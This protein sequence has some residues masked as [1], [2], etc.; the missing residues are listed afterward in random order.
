MRRVARRPRSG[1][2]V[3]IVTVCRNSEG[4]IGRTIESVLRQSY[5]HIEYLI[6]DGVSED[7]TVAVAESYRPK[8]RGRLTITSEPDRGIYDAMN[9]GI[10]RSGGAIIGILNADDLYEPTAIAAVADSYRRNGPGVHYGI[11]RVVEDGREVALRRVSEHA[12]YRDVVGHPAYFV[13]ADTYAQHGVFRTDYAYGSDYD[14]MLRFVAKKVP[15]WP[16]DSVVATFHQGGASAVHGT[17]TLEE[18][19]RIRHEHGYIS[20]ARMWYQILKNRLLQSVDRGGS[21][22][23]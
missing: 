1:P 13:T 18:L 16:I 23:V 12:L 15:F 11:L 8:F 14:L 2:L 6:V 21:R 4:T 22:P 19:W 17:R 7:Q 5:P 10:A 9:K 3:S 20:S